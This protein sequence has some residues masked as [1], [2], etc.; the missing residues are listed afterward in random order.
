VPACP[1]KNPPQALMGNS[2]GKLEK[3]DISQNLVHV[4]SLV[5]LLKS[6]S[7]R[8]RALHFRK[9]NM[10]KKYFVKVLDPPALGCVFEL[11]FGLDP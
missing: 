2:V 1:Q 8:L 4:N 10:N 7:P 6:Q 5:L 9:W 11:V 3:M